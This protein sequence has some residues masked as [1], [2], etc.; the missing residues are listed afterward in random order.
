MYNFKKDIDATYD[1]EYSKY[2]SLDEPLLNWPVSQACTASQF[3]EPAYTYWAKAIKEQPRLHRKQ[4]EF[5]FILQVLAREGMLAPQTRGLGFGVGKEPLS[6]LFAARGISILATDLDPSVSNFAGW[7]QTNQHAKNIDALNERGICDDKDFRKLVSFRYM[8]MNEINIQN[9]N[10]D[11]CWS[12]CAL[13]HLGSIEKGL[14][15]IR[16]S[17]DCLLPGGV[18]V[19]TTELNCVSN[20][21]TLDDAGTVLFRMCDFVQ[22]SKE[23]ISEGHHIK[24]NF[25]LGASELDQH[26]DVPP[27]SGDKHLKLQL[28]NWVTTSFG[29]VVKKS[30]RVD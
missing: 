15:F 10:F 29:L 13:E 25:N 8:D 9:P 23:L 11:F 21:D 26:L 19:H 22:L 14:K 1:G 5:C 16:S 18:A 27:Y 28:S 20:T 17:L 4:W 6:S 2:L 3:T 30:S 7:T 12:A 24:L